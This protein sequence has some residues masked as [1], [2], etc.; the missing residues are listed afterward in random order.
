MMIQTS[1]VGVLND[2]F[3]AAARFLHSVSKSTVGMLKQ[4]FLTLL[5][6]KNTWHGLTQRSGGGLGCGERFR[7]AAAVPGTVT[8]H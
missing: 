2:S 7:V 4:G 6:S 8:R 3:R 1:E 5:A